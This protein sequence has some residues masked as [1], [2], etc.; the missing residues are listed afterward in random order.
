MFLSFLFSLS[1]SPLLLFFLLLLST[2][3]Q[4]LTR[5]RLRRCQ[6]ISIDTSKLIRKKKKRYVKVERAREKKKKK[7]KMISMHQTGWIEF[8]MHRVIAIE[9]EKQWS[10]VIE[11]LFHCC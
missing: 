5:Y 7:K 6:S 4:D 8:E 10:I 3:T 1:L 11:M 2:P 9:G